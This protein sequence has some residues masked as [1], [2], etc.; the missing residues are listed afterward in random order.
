MF[1]DGMDQLEVLNL[2]ENQLTGNLPALDLPA[3]KEV[4]FSQNQFNGT[5]VPNY[6]LPN[7]EK[8]HFHTNQLKGTI[9]QFTNLPKLKQLSAFNNDFDSLATQNAFILSG[10]PFEFLELENNA[11]TFDDIRPNIQRIVFTGVPNDHGYA[12]QDSA[13]Q[14]KTVSATIGQP[15]SIA[16]GF[17][18]NEASSFYN[19]FKDGQ[20]YPPPVNGSPYLTFFVH[21]STRCRRV[22]R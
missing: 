12:P 15:L 16:L 7:L 18:E 4:F 9:P 17:D 6:A 3:L 1:I 11:F 14:A 19:W 10:Q 5:N 21:T 13:G 8:L 20:A 22:L 2:A